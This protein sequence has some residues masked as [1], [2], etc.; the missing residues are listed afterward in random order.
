MCYVPFSRYRAR[1]V[2]DRSS[3]PPRSAA[4][5]ESLASRAAINKMFMLGGFW[6]CITNWCVARR[7][8]FADLVA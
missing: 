1:R 6:C 2:L 3:H 4:L 8:G 5:C 7:R